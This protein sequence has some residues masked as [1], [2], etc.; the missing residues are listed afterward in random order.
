[1]YHGSNITNGS[2][3]A[4][5]EKS[6]Q[7]LRN[8]SK[9]DYGSIKSGK[10]LPDE[11]QQQQQQF[12]NISKMPLWTPLIPTAD[13]IL[14]SGPITKFLTAYSKCVGGISPHR[15]DTNDSEGKE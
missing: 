13:Y 8:A 5:W 6:Y 12:Q 2:Q 3:Y 4:L 14:C 11:Q 1:M 15:T 10:S 9:M 7:Q